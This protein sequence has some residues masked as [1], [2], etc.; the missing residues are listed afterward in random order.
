MRLGREI[1]D[2]PGAMFVEQPGDQLAVADVAVHEVVATVVG[3]RVQRIE[4]AGVG[5]L[6]EIDDRALFLGQP[7]AHEATADE[8]GAAGNQ[9]C[10]HE[11]PFSAASG[12]ELV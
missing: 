6:V 5:Q 10:V 1:D 8:A 4:V 9:D 3:D 11:N 12:L 7:L 2:R